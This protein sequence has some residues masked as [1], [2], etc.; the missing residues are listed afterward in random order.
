[1]A[2]LSSLTYPPAELRVELVRLLYTAL[3]QVAS[4]TSCIC[5]AGIFA[6]W[7]SGG[8]WL[9]L[10]LLAW[11]LTFAALRIG[12][13]LRFPRD[14]DALDLCSAK[15]WEVRYAVGAIGFAVITGIQTNI[16]FHSS[17]AG[18]WA[19]WTGLS[20]GMCG[21]A[22]AT[23]LSCL[24]WIPVTT[25]AVLLT[26]LSA[27]FLSSGDPG[28]MLGGLLVPLYGLSYFEACR[29]TGQSLI[30]R[31]LAEREARHLAAH[32]G[33]TGLPNRL[34]FQEQ[35]ERATATAITDGKP[36]AV[37]AI[38][39]DGFK[40]VN[41]TYGHAGG[42]ELLRQ[43]THRLRAATMGVH[44]AARLGGDEFAIVT[45]P[46]NDRERVASLAAKFL[47]SLAEPYT[48]QGKSVTTVSA[49]IGVALWGLN[50]TDGETLIRYADE[51]L[52]EAKRGGRKAWRLSNAQ[53]AAA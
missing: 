51:A 14:P 47:T 29:H 16:G 23:R 1:M 24:P 20:M 9:S 25:G 21:G 12:V 37:L 50:G 30:A 45:A 36:F 33:L 11:T 18:E 32:D 27:A 31:M 41:D 38:D 28:G 4:G 5:I 43:V 10:A 35:I 44:Y 42:D 34:S 17:F 19:L 2:S 22:S 53:L 39:L 13:L 26:A 7:R 52:Y 6:V 46:I 15:R 48:V 49:S 8:S 40:L 3:P